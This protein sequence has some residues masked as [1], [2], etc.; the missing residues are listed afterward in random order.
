[1]CPKHETLPNLIKENT[2]TQKGEGRF[3]K[4]ETFGIQK[5]KCSNGATKKRSRDNP[6]GDKRIT[7]VRSPHLLHEEG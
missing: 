7:Y 3:S 2:P 5:C 6:K 4:K 1:V